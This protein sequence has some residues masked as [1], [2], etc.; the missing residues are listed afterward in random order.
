MSVHDVVYV[1]EVPR[2][3]AT[4]LISKTE[5]S[6]YWEMGWKPLGSRI[7]VSTRA[8]VNEASICQESVLD[9]PE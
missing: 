4:S 8:D 3:A 7:F 5:R 1:C 2:T 9:V 6:K